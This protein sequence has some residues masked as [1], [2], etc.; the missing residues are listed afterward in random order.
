[1]HTSADSTNPQRDDVYEL[2]DRLA[3]FPASDGDA[4]LT[5]LL[6]TLCAMVA[7]QN[8]LWSV[9]VRLPSPA[10]KDPLFGWRPRLVRVLHPAP[11]MVASV[12]EQYDTL[13]SGRVDPSHVVA[14]SGD[15]PFCA[16]LLFEAMPAEWFEGEHYRRH[17]LE[18]GHGDSIQMR[19]SLNDDVRIHLFV[20]RDVR[21]PR[22]SA[23]DLER[24]SFVM[25]G[26]KWFN[27]QQLLSHGL[28]IA[29][30]PLTPAERKVLRGLLDGHMEK[31]IAL[32]LD[33]S[34]NTTH[35]H[36]KSIYA[37]FGVRNRAALAALW[38]GKLR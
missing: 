9:V 8:A 10:P 17:Y 27:R 3:E 6:T 12:Q 34:P 38:L 23:P 29:N 16:N 26:L 35:F 7:A 22:F 32:K 13:W 20:F 5:H 31:E 14:A 28:L 36:V 25:H 15:E 2:W 30:A 37:K 21:S 33:Q 19:C 18:V 4:A 24:L 1:M 11:A